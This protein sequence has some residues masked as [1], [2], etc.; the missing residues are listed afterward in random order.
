MA[1]PTASRATSPRAAELPHAA[2]PATSIAGTGFTS[3]GIDQNPAF[4]D[5]VIDSHFGAA[6]AD[7]VAYVVS[8]ALRRYDV[9]RIGDGQARAAAVGATSRAWAL[10]AA[11]VYSKDESVQDYTGV[12]HLPGGATWSFFGRHTPTPKMCQLVRAWGELLDVAT[13]LAD[14]G[15]GGG[16]QPLDEPM[17]YDLV[18]VGREVLAQI[19]TPLSMNLSDALHAAPHPRPAEL[20]AYGSAYLSVL[21]DLDEL[22]ATDTAFLLGPWLQMARRVGDAPNASD[23]CTGASAPTVPPEVTGCA[24]FFEWN[25]R[26]Q[27]TTWNPVPSRRAKAQPKGPIDYASKHWSG[28]IRDYYRERAKLLVAAAKQHAAAGK[29]FDAAAD[30]AV[31][32]PHAYA[33]QVATTQYPTAPVGDALVVSRAMHAKYAPRFAGCGGGVQDR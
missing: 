1:A 4:Y 28:L 25:A 26:C 31:R 10:L 30:D 5:L 15:G 12:P 23:D 16:G 8:R 27:L 33:F 20:D 2:L 7:P 3:E 22:V 14:A 18:D 6:A 11:S 24:H 29:R 9:S 21:S 32:A 17:R 19:A 13:A